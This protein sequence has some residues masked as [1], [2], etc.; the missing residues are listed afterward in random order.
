MGRRSRARTAPEPLDADDRTAPAAPPRRRPADSAPARGLTP[1]RKGIA[2]TLGLSVL[3]AAL[4]VI[5]VAVLNGLLGATIVLVV[6]VLGATGIRGFMRA[7]IAGAALTD[8]DRIFQTLAIGLLL[9]ALA[10]AVAVFVLEL[11]GA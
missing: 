10:F 1:V 7:R 2:A 8:D 9:I 6:A 11:V 5:G 3:L 4:V